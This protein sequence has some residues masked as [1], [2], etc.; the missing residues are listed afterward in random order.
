MPL[1]PRSC[2]LPQ[3]YTGCVDLHM[4]WYIFDDACLGL[5]HRLPVYIFMVAGAG[6]SK[7][8]YRHL[9][10]CHDKSSDNMETTE[11]NC[12]ESVHLVLEDMALDVLVRM[13]TF[14]RYWRQLVSTFSLASRDPKE[15]RR[16]GWQKVLQVTPSSAAAGGGQE[17]VISLQRASVDGDSSATP[18]VVKIGKEGSWGICT[19]VILDAAA[20]I[21]TCKIPPGTGH[22]L[23]VQ[24]VADCMVF[25][26]QFILL[27][28]TYTPSHAWLYLPAQ[29]ATNLHY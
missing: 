1:S 15:V 22:G 8:K 2:T 3:Y 19:D 9:S 7:R 23:H 11:D 5:M 17:M 18:P 16:S 25:V 6:F 29:F 12:T 20:G 28:S 10:W 4:P 24:V 21:I 14:R 27:H 13:L 26:L